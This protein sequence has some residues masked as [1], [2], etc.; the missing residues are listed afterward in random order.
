MCTYIGIGR[1]RH[2]GTS[3]RHH[4][5]H[6]DTQ[7]HDNT[8]KQVHD[9][10]LSKR[11]LLVVGVVSEESTLFRTRQRVGEMWSTKPENILVYSISPATRKQP[12]VLFWTEDRRKKE[13]FFKSI[14]SSNSGKALD[15]VIRLAAHPAIIEPSSKASL[16]RS[17]LLFPVL[18]H[19]YENLINQFDWFLCASS[20]AHVNFES[21]KGFLPHLNTKSSLILGAPSASAA[22]GSHGGCT[23]REG[24]GVVISREVLLEIGNLIKNRKCQAWNCLTRKL[25]LKCLYD[26]QVGDCSL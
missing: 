12:N 23:V 11:N 21:I 26:Y 5:R 16:F 10:T 18:L 2:Q 15:N 14:S 7:D 25:D 6:Q 17:D 9:S 19:M 20:D 1:Q 24:L 3:E 4:Q 13:S 8:F 22:V